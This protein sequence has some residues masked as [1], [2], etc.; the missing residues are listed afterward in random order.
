M[1]V[2]QEELELH[3]PQTDH[4]HLVE[5]LDFHKD[6]VLVELKV[7]LVVGLHMGLE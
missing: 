7:V 6:L 2:E 3:K 4:Q 5:Q 1:A